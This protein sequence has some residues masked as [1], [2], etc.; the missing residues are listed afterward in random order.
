MGL[1]LLSAS[2]SRNAGHKINL[3]R[4]MRYV[5]LF[6]IAGLFLTVGRLFRQLTLSI[7]F[8]G[9]DESVKSTFFPTSSS[10]VGMG[11]DV[12]RTRKTMRTEEGEKHASRVFR[13]EKQRIDITEGREEEETKTRTTVR[14]HKLDEHETAKKILRAIDSRLADRLYPPSYSTPTP[15]TQHEHDGNHR[16][17]NSLSWWS[18]TSRSMWKSDEEY[19]SKW[20]TFRD[21]FDEEKLG[22]SGGDSGGGFDDWSESKHENEKG[23]VIDYEINRKRIGIVHCFNSKDDEIISATSQGVDLC[24]TYESEKDDD[25]Y[26]DALYAQ[27]RFWDVNTIVVVVD[28]SSTTSDT[29]EI[30]NSAM[31]LKEKSSKEG[32]IAIEVVSSLE[33]SREALF[34]RM[35]R[36]KAVALAGYDVSPVSF[37]AGVSR[38]DGHFI[39]PFLGIS[40]M[41]GSGDSTRKDPR[42]TTSVANWKQAVMFTQRVHWRQHYPLLE[43]NDFVVPEENARTSATQPKDESTRTCEDLWGWR[44]LQNRWELKRSDAQ[45][46]QIT[47]SRS[48]RHPTARGFI[49]MEAKLNALPLRNVAIDVSPHRDAMSKNPWHRL[50]ALYATFVAKSRFFPNRDATSVTLLL[51]CQNPEDIPSEYAVLGKSRCKRSSDAIQFDSVVKIANDGLLW[52]L[53]WDGSLPCR[54]ESL[55][56]SFVNLLA[57]GGGEIF[58]KPKVPFT[59]RPICFMRRLNTSVRRLVNEEG[60]LQMLR[61]TFPANEVQLL[62]IQASDGIEK[63]RASMQKCGIFLGAHGAG[64]INEIYTL[65]DSIIFEMVPDN[66]PAYYRNCAVL[67]GLKY[68]DFGIRGTTETKSVTVDVSTLRDALRSIMR[69]T[70]KFQ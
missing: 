25:A 20:K 43:K 56:K 38:Y 47:A 2:Q 27:F 8:R 9:D 55:F 50:T 66:R 12:K 26:F 34:A 69:S 10:S 3:K 4:M 14:R 59:D 13:D 44:G 54:D 46:M 17:R 21:D 16:Q 30:H 5:I 67:R 23:H 60:V 41:Y 48:N 45:T 63:T 24:E 32:K 49:S 42:V 57:G 18:L 28:V 64:M 58:S 62:N 6:L 70:A 35:R 11:G 65:K 22:S 39:A 37:L 29:I 40:T 7:A 53:A 1:K 68:V 51:P 61:D 19:A 36:A 33:E 31:K 52:D 15:I